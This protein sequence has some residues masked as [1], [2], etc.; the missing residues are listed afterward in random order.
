MAIKMVALLILQVSTPNSASVNNYPQASVVLLSIQTNY[1]IA[2]NKF[3]H[4]KLF[5]F[6]P[7]SLKTT[8]RQHMLLTA[9]KIVNT[10]KKIKTVTLQA[11]FGAQ[12]S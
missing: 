10:S 11:K 1:I 7:N 4:S 3:G 2:Q 6:F 5:D 9:D 12:S 8:V